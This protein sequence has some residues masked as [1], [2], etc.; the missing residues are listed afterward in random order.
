MP[1]VRVALV[2]VGG[3]GYKLLEAINN[4]EQAELVA[5]CDTNA[6]ITDAMADEL[7][8]PGYYDYW[9]MFEEEDLHAAVISLPHHLY[10]DAI[11]AAFEAGVDV[12]KEK[13]LAK[14]LEDAQKILDMTENY[15]RRLMVA[16]QSKFSAPFSTAKTLVEAGKIGEIF[17]TH[18]RILYRWERAFENE[19]GWRGKKNLSGGVAIVDSGWHILDL[20]YWFKGMP[21]KVHAFTGSMR[22]VPD[23]DYD[24][25]DKAVVNLEFPD[26]SIGS[27]VMCF[28]TMPGETRLLLSGTLGSLDITREGVMHYEEQRGLPVPMPFGRKDST[29][30]Q[31]DH[32][33]ECLIKDRPFTGDV[34]EAF[35]VA[36]I[37]D[38]AYRSAETGEVVRLE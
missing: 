24:T 10:P 3:R 22:G 30:A 5:I 32:F 29:Q 37:V 35:E 16:A 27:A 14:D 6:Q 28:I 33:I 9:R 18:G 12:L 2:G 21:S 1:V 13:P 36:R 25:D 20:I 38:A 31:F 26:G 19:W 17:L 11:H 4:N 34:K 7:D 15:G 23:A 8:V